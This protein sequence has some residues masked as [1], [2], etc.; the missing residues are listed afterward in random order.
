MAKMAER[1]KKTQQRRSRSIPSEQTLLFKKQEGAIGLG[2]AGNEKGRTL[3]GIIQGAFLLGRA[4][5]KAEPQFLGVK[6]VRSDQKNQGR[7]KKKRTTGKK[8]G[9]SHLYRGSHRSRSA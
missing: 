1:R 9:N 6:A 2:T 5:A 4:W 3:E 8:C 7:V